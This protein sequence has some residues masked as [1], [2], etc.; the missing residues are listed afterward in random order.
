MDDSRLNSTTFYCQLHFENFETIHG[1]FQIQNGHC[2]AQNGH[3]WAFLTF[4]RQ[5]GIKQYTKMMIPDSI[6]Q[7]FTA[8]PMKI[9]S[10]GSMF[11]FKSKF[12]NNGHLGHTTGHFGFVNYQGS[13]H[14][15]SNL[16][17][18]KKLYYEVSKYL[19]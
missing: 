10:D 9:F 7:I 2:F 13:F 15:Y 1:H 5:E 8:D 3:F 14:K 6:V 4:K 12:P 11:I 19:F 17:C 16:I 18:N